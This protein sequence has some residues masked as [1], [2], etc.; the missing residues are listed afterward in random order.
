MSKLKIVTQT[1]NIEK[2]GWM[3]DCAPAALMAAANFLT[4]SK[5]NSFDGVKFLT[6]VGRKDI[7]GQGTPTS[8]LQLV[9]AAPLVGLK[10][11]YAKSWDE[12]VAALKAGAIVGIN[13]QQAKGYPA[14]VPMSAWH[15]SHQKRNP[16]K[17]YGHMTC[18]ALSEG[19]VQWADPTMSGKGKEAYAVVVSL[20][21]LKAIAASKGEAPHKRCLI[22]TAVP[23]KL[24]AP[25]PIA[26]LRSQIVPVSSSA[27]V[28]TTQAARTTSK[29]PVQADLRH[30][31]RPK[32]YPSV[33]TPSQLVDTVLALKVAR[34]IVGK[35]EV[36]KGDNTMKDQIIAATLDAVQAALSTAIAVF[37]GLGVSIFDLNGDGVKAVAASA[38]SAALLVLQRW[39]DEDNTRYG[40]TR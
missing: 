27:L 24:S 10:P 33:K 3:D 13:V 18:A 28:A 16:G 21:D 34:A 23:K 14:T 15:K 17:T 37:L 30:Q 12:V 39:L 19:K 36:A 6:K 2:G 8:L 1:D 11:K 9:K 20:A 29:A 4:G 7:E 26:D 35:I 22:F 5:Y 31:E 38:I 32:D 25:A 40:R